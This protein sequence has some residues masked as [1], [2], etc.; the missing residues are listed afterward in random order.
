MENYKEYIKSSKDYLKSISERCYK[1][2]DNA[3]YYQVDFN[4]IISEICFAR[5]ERHMNDKQNS[6]GYI[7]KLPYDKKTDKIGEHLKYLNYDLILKELQDILSGIYNVTINKTGYKNVKLISFEPKVKISKNLDYAIMLVIFC[8]LRGMDCE[9]WKLW[10]NKGYK[11]APQNLNEY[12]YEY[13]IRTNGYSGHDINDDLARFFNENK[14]PEKFLKSISNSFILYLKNTFGENG[15]ATKENYSKYFDD[16]FKGKSW[17]SKM[18]TGCYNMI[19][20][21]TN[22]IILEEKL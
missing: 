19:Q 8:M 9:Y 17:Q 16:T 18:Q 15:V 12:I 11:N 2:G 13:S 21:T 20:N 7:L 5:L 14:R 6:M 4:D 1:Y 3:I 10:K 22:K